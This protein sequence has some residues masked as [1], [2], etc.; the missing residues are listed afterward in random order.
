MSLSPNDGL[1]AKN[2]SS[3]GGVPPRSVA[4][5]KGKRASRSGIRGEV[6]GEVQPAGRCA[7]RTGG[8]GGREGRGEVPWDGLLAGRARKFVEFAEKG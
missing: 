4:D 2:A 1:Y 5:G 6:E 3:S 8:G 7:Q